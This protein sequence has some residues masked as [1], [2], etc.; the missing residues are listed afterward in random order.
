MAG[1]TSSEAAARLR[2]MAGAVLAALSPTPPVPVP[3]TAHAPMLRALLMHALPLLRASMHQS[4]A[5]QVE[6][7]LNAEPAFG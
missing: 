6:A 7:L 1:S 2:A 3:P 5:D 4:L